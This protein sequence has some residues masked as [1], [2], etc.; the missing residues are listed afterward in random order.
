M[1]YS[2]CMSNTNPRMPKQSRSI[3]TKEQ[4][5]EAASQ[6][7]AEEGYHNTNTKKIAARAGIAVGSFYAYYRN[8]KTVFLEVIQSYYQRIQ[9][10]AFNGLEEMNQLSANS[11]RTPKDVYSGARLLASVIQQLY[12]AHNISPQLHREITG[13]RY[14]D[15][16][17][18]KL[19][20]EEEAKTVLRIQE[21]LVLFGPLLKVKD[22]EAASHVVHRS[23]EEVIHSIKIF[24]S[25][26]E[27]KR[28]IAELNA[29]LSRYLFGM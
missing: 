2:H 21:I 16:D 1:G 15:T 25:S 10:D 24:G 12:E 20:T 22:I 8:K 6:L 26:I 5:F 3:A 18:D 27:P 29:M 11:V 23:A 9:K 14:T 7:F 4:L 13:M 19:I 17:V 28:L